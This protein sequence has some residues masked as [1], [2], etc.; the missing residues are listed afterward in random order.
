MSEQ[1]AYS[2]TTFEYSNN[3]IIIQ[4]NNFL[5]TGNEYELRFFAVYSY[6][7][8]KQPVK[9]AQYQA[10]G[11]L[12]GYSTY[13]YDHNGNIK[14]SE[15]YTINPSGNP[16]QTSGT[17]YR[18][19]DNKNPYRNVYHLLENLPYSI[20]RN[21]II[22]TSRTDYTTDPQGIS[23]TT[24]TKENAYNAYGYPTAMDEQGNNFLLEYK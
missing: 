1:Y 3:N 7:D 12:Y 22:A 13:N 4:R 8:Q 15:H 2:K 6:K 19:D 17:T 14:A 11:S 10:D 5:R 21:N 23:H 16:V 20:N 9:E 24:T 18:Y